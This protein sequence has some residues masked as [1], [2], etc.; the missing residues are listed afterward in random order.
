MKDMHGLAPVLCMLAVAAAQTSA[1][2][3]QF[4]CPMDPDVRSSSPGK[5]P[6]CGMAL[7]AGIQ[8]PL[9]YRLRLSA[10]PS[11]VPAGEPVELRFEIVDPRTD[12]RAEKFELVHEKS[13]HLFLVSADLS[14]F[15][16]DHP[17]AGADGMFRYRTTLPSPGIYRVLADCYPSGGTPQLLP[18][19]LTT[20]G[21]DKPISAALTHPPPDLSP[22]QSEN[23][24]VSLRLDP[25]EPIPGK[26]TMMFFRV[27]PSEGIEPYL[28]AWGHLLAVSD[29][30][31]DSIHEHPTYANS[32]P[33]IQFDVFFPRQASYKVWVQFQRKG[34]V[35]TTAF[36]IPVR[37]P[38]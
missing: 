5:C 3:V 7:E 2:P 15:V 30:L 27:E 36:V 13:F 21:Y 6:R 22:K 24:R 19:Y 9:K 37:E 17:E 1:P 14:Y 4:I 28:G 29:D 8:E 34:V 10:L 20:A 23:L 16:H 31:V 18:A 32:G 12:K 33:E 38:R 26:K 11:A 35:N 25:P